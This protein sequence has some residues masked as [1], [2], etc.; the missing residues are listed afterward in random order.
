ME[1]E[2]GS[3]T[4]ILNNQSMMEVEGYEQFQV[5]FQEQHY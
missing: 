1:I 5:Q 4:I 2:A 3:G